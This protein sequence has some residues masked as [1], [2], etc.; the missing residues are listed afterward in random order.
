VPDEAKATPRKSPCASCP[1]RTDVPSGIWDV[2]EYDKLVRYD[3]EIME[4]AIKGAAALFFCH[5]R[6]EEL[7]AGWVGCHDMNNNLA[8]RMHASK[9]DIDAVLDYKTRVPLFSSGA[10]A[11]RHGIARVSRP[12]KAAQKRIDKLSKL[13]EAKGDQW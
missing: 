3:G 1:Y 13:R 8:V 9:I 4:Q 6:T 2:S 12:G 10:E 11:R 5:Q 7:C